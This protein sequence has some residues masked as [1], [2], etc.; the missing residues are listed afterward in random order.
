M[1]LANNVRTVHS[2]YHLLS[3]SPLKQ[4]DVDSIDAFLLPGVKEKSAS[5]AVLCLA[6]DKRLN[7]PN[8]KSLQVAKH[9]IARRRWKVDFGVTFDPSYPIHL[10]N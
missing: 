3:L 10:C 5:L 2:F 8:G 4:S 7:L 6:C 1:V 9:L